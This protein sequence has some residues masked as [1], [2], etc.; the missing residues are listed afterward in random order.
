MR[1]ISY[2]ENN[3][4]MCYYKILSRY[5][6]IARVFGNLS[7]PALKLALKEHVKQLAN[8]S[9]TDRIQELKTAK[10]TLPEYEYACRKENILRLLQLSLPG[11][12][13]VKLV[14]KKRTGASLPTLM[15]WLLHSPI[16]GP[17]SL[18]LVPL[19]ISTS[20]MIG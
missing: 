10:E 9:I 15:K 18:R 13:S 14:I 19:L 12:R 3:K 11:G 16:T 5:S 7:G 6:E 17:R 4:A 1:A 2:L 8:T 20:W